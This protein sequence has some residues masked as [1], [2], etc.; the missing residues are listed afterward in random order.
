MNT[1]KTEHPLNLFLEKIKKIKDFHFFKHVN[2]SFQ[3]IPDA[4]RGFLFVQQADIIKTK[5]SSD[6][7]IYLSGL[8]IDR[9]PRHFFIS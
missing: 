8:L 2:S 1:T 9:H 6:E 5:L 7:K 4:I 3:C